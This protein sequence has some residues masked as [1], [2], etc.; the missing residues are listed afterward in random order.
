MADC[1]LSPAF[2]LPNHDGNC[3]ARESTLHRADRICGHRSGLHAMQQGQSELFRRASYYEHCR[4]SLWWRRYADIAIVSKGMLVR[5]M[6]KSESVDIPNWLLIYVVK[7][8]AKVV[9]HASKLQKNS[10]KDEAQTGR[11]SRGSGLLLRDRICSQR[12][13]SYYNL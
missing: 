4:L 10:C 13:H 5:Q 11:Q 8:F 7:D 1:T 12:R 2:L 9:V 6:L 3:R